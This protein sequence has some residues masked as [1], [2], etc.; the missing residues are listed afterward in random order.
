[1]KKFNKFETQ[2]LYF[3]ICDTANCFGNDSLLAFI[4]LGI[5]NVLKYRSWDT[6]CSYCY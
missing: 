3:Y 5:W 2:V 4:L 1:M 6:L